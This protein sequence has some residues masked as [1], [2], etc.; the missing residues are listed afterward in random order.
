MISYAP[1]ATQHISFIH[2]SQ[3]PFFY[4]LYFHFWRICALIWQLCR[5]VVIMN[6]VPRY[7]FENKELAGPEFLIPEQSNRSLG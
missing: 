1:T 7:G 2:L 4:L 5:T 3:T 6:S